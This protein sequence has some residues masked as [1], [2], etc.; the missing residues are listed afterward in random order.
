MGGS[1]AHCGIELFPVLQVLFVLL[2]SDC[3]AI[4]RDL[5]WGHGGL[6]GA[7]KDHERQDRGRYIRWRNN[8]KEKRRGRKRKRD[9]SGNMECKKGREEEI[10]KGKE[11]GRNA[12]KEGL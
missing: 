1:L 5:L 10:G 2:H 3:I 9:N 7:A 12:K 4:T 11:K 8:G 6:C